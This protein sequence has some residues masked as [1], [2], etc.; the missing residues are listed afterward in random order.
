MLYKAEILDT[1]IWHQFQDTH[2]SICKVSVYTKPSQPL[3]A[4]FCFQVREFEFEISLIHLLKNYYQFQWEMSQSVQERCSSLL[5]EANNN[6]T[7]VTESFLWVLCGDSG[8]CSSLLF[9]N[10]PSSISVLWMG[11]YKPFLCSRSV[12]VSKSFS[13]STLESRHTTRT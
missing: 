6:K 13:S 2:L 3:T 7:G 5:K 8:S 9:Q 12:Q 4:L 10:K 11:L 1:D